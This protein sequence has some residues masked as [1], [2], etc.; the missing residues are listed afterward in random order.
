[1]TKV[2]PN[3]SGGACVS[4]AERS[5]SISGGDAVVLT[6]WKK[7]L[8]PNC[9]GFTVFDARGDLVFRVDNYIARNKRHILLM[10]AAGTPLLTIRRK[11]LSFGDT[12][13]VFE[14]E[15]DSLKPLFTARK[16]VNILNKC[17]A[18]V[19]SSSG[20][21]TGTMKKE[22]AYEM[23]GSYV[24]RC[25]TFYNNNRRKVAEIK[26]KEAAAGGVAFGADI[27]RLI[28][29]PHMD[30]ALAMAFLILLHHMFGSR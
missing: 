4:E 9:N 30:T 23:E 29:Q 8:L 15:D 12:W 5:K 17:L 26:M 7:S 3:A 14:G 19:F 28:V 11:R 24:Q 18:Q 22:V 2:H 1:M 10:D 20:T 16:N 6:V 21:G 27:F 13:L 25:C